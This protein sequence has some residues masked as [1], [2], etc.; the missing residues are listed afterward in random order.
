MVWDLF[1]F[2]RDFVELAVE[3]EPFINEI[4]NCQFLLD[5]IDPAI[6]GMKDM[7]DAS[8]LLWEGCL[9]LAIGYF[10]V[11][12]CTVMAFRY[13]RLKHENQNQGETDDM[14]K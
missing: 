5:N 13:I 1:Y 3:F 10:V 7:R 11:Y 9:V 2:L 12:N 4:A 8:I 14:H 6:D